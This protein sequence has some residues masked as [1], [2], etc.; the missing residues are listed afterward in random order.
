MKRLISTIL[1]VAACLSLTDCGKIG[2]NDSKGPVATKVEFCIDWSG[3]SKDVTDNFDIIFTGKDFSGSSFNFPLTSSGSKT[4]VSGKVEICDTEDHCPFTYACSVTP[5]ST[6]AEKD[7][8]DGTYNLQVKAR[9][10]DAN[11]NALECCGGG[12]DD[13][14]L[15]IKASG[16][17]KET[18][19]L[20]AK[21]MFQKTVSSSFVEEEKTFVFFR[22]S[23]DF[24]FSHSTKR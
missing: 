24:S 23:A 10:Y 13:M 20:S 22:N 16:V 15:E 11:G 2:N 1:V 3:V 6:F 8:Y 4:F 19:K 7:S 9:F 12:N 21:E 5:K 14:I 18:T 17:I